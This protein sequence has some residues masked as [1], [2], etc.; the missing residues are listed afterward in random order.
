MTFDDLLDIRTGDADLTMG[1]IPSRIG[2]IGTAEQWAI[3]AAALRDLFVQTLGERPPVAC[4]L[5]PEILDEADLGEYIRRRVAYS[6]EPDERISAYLLL[7]KRRRARAPAVICIHPTTPLG[8]E[9]AIGNDPTA[10]GQD[11]AYALHLVQRGYVTLAYDLMSVGERCFPGCKAFETG[12]FYVR[13]PRWSACGKDILDMRRAVDYLHT[14]NEVDPARIGSIGHSQGGGVT[15][16]AMA[17]DDR[18]KIGVSSCGMWP[19][20]L[21]K[22]PFNA[23]RTGWWVGR[24]LLRP[25]CW[26]GKDFPVD[27]HEH[28]ALIAPRAILAITA[29]NDCGYT[30]AEADTVRAAFTNLEE[31]VA[32]VFALL[33]ADG[34]FHGVL[35]PHGHG[36]IEEQ[37]AI[38]Y[39][40]LDEHL[41][42]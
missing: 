35:H 30:H 16:H 24:P 8:K 13:H 39:A 38:A 17:L 28:L 29:L 21:S 25:Y 18:I 15:I 33:G 40:F 41:K 19:T 2:T 3:K 23:A 4:A 22:N 14:V 9:Q 42:P 36:F 32:S 1:G 37:R 26:T 6:V 10:T 20:R 5:A 31:N 11:R 12:P 27:L 34:N 7:P